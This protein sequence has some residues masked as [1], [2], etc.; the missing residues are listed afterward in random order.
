M[1]NSEHSVHNKPEQILERSLSAG[2][3]SLLDTILQ[4]VL[5]YGSFFITARFLSPEDYG[6]VALALIY[7]N[8]LDSLTAI[9]FDTA[10]TQKKE[11]EERSLLSVVWT[12]N[13][14]RSAIVFIVVFFTSF[15]FAQFFH[16]ENALLLFQLSALTLLVQAFANIGQIYFFRKLDFKK[17]FIR[18][19]AS[20]G[21]TALVTVVL[22]I[23]LHSYWALFI[24]SVSGML[25]AVITTYI[26]QE[27]RPRM[28]ISFRR[29]APLMEYSQWVFGQGVVTRISQT[30]EDSIIG[31]FTNPAS[32]GNYSK[33]KSLAYAPTSPL[34]NIIGKIGFSAFVAVN[35]SLPHIREGFHKSFDVA[36]TI[37]IPFIVGIWLFGE[38]F[39]LIVLGDTWMG[40]T[41]LLKALVIVSGLNTCIL[42]LTTM[43]MNALDKPR[44][45]FR[46]NLLSLVAIIIFL[47]LLAISKGISGAAISLL[48]T[49]IIVNGYALYLLHVVIAPTWRKITSTTFVV[50]AAA[51]LPALIAFPLLN[52]PISSNTIIFFGIGIGYTLFYASIIVAFGRM[53]GTGPLQTLIIIGRSLFR[54]NR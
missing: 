12:F 5:I 17:V 54:K 19:M 24:G 32:V 9:A 41:P 48:I 13:L 15:L 36:V 22:A 26:L 1:N 38:Q 46:L 4:K 29:L 27:F 45:Q 14:L 18:D 20:Y 39:V 28:D 40:I 10:L 47:P 3:W 21:T 25:V 44:L 52:A 42:S 7:P 53:G 51:L 49:A 16:A 2:Y 11:G 50:S 8:L 30:L 23:A 34:A 37:A 6:L 35:E 43:T 33:A 31:H